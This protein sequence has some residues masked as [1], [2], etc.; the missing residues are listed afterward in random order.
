MNT[1]IIV[2]AA[3][4]VAGTGGPALAQD[5]VESAIKLPEACQKAAQ[6]PGGMGDMGMANMME[7]MQQHMGGS[8]S[9]AT[10][11]YMQAMTAMHMPMMQGAMAQDADVAF[12]C[13]MIAHHLGAI[14]MAKV[15][16]QHGKDGEAKKMAQKTIDEQSADIEEMTKWV[17]EHVAG[18]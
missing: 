13:S 10:R 11:G 1:R 12:N 6:M 17:E 9:E 15:E 4:L 3:L 14:A 16:L 2:A 18:K 7:T 8:M 5:I